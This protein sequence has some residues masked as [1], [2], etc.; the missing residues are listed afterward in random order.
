M[1]FRYIRSFPWE[2]N[3]RMEEQMSQGG[4]RLVFTLADNNCSRGIVQLEIGS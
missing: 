2:I 3:P 1:I 4:Q